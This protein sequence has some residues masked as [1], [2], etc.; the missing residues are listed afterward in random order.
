MITQISGAACIMEQS[1]TACHTLCRDFGLEQRLSAAPSVSRKR[2]MSSS[3]QDV[4]PSTPI[5]SWT[6][7]PTDVANSAGNGSTSATS[8]RSPTGNVSFFKSLNPDKKQTKGTLPSSSWSSC[9]TT[10]KLADG[11]LPKRRGPK[12]DS[13]PALTRRQ[14]LNR[15]AQRQVTLIDRKAI[16]DVC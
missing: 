16:L 15:Q 8:D 6:K 1:L 9:P 4:E 2:S 13:K 11:Q 7:S 10:D 5:D 12:P 3:E 14:E